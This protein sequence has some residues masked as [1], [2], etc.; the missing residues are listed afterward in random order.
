M[1]SLMLPILGTTS[2]VTP[3]TNEKKVSMND[4]I[5]DDIAISIL[6]KLPV[7]SV[8]RFSC[9]SKTWSLLFENPYFLNKFRNN[10]V[11]K[12]LPLYD[13]DAYLL[14]KRTMPQTKLSLGLGEKE[15]ALD[16]DLP[17]IF[18]GN[19]NSDFDILG[20]AINGIICL[21]DYHDHTNILF[22]NPYTQEIKVIPYSPAKFLPPDLTD[23]FYLHG[24][25][26]DHV[27]D[28]FK[29]IMF[30]NCDLVYDEYWE[31]AMPDPFWE[32][33]SLK[34]N[35]WRRLKTN[36]IPYINYVPVGLEVYLDGMCHWLGTTD[37]ETYHVVSFNFSNE[38][39]FA[40]PIDEV[41]PSCFKL[42]V[43]N[44]SLAMITMNDNTMS[45]NISIL[46]EIGV[47]ESRTTLFNVGPLS[48]SIKDFIAAGKKGNIFFQEKN[49]KI[50]CFDLTTGMIKDIGL[51]EKSYI[52]QVVFYK[53]NPNRIEEL[54]WFL[55]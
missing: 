36:D 48:S 49:G 24:F 29:V 14:Y 6:S 2:M 21:Y 53:K 7:K 3:T 32:I 13:D 19:A 18:H 15:I 34:R 35:S 22:C 26:Y 33:Y 54:I 25:G 43:I 1:C 41:V 55:Y 42:V 17:S 45:F 44:G 51:E 12:P 20:S 47:K 27:H 5:C 23:A 9:A 37:G 4:Y 30:V 28:D 52:D 8:K 10:L 50:A 31:D 38:V 11:S 39:F 16:L 46:G 40:T